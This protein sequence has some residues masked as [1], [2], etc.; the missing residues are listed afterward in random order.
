MKLHRYSGARLGIRAEDPRH[1]YI[2]DPVMR[3]PGS[4]CQR[5]KAIVGGPFWSTSTVPSQDGAFHIKVPREDRT[6][7][8]GRALLGVRVPGVMAGS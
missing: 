3:T 7:V 2:S 8:Q 1:H 6:S 4:A 5:S